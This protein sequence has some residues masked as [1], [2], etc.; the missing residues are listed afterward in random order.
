MDWWCDGQEYTKIEL[1]KFYWFHIIS[2]KWDSLN[3][4]NNRKCN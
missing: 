1:S 4:I 2:K 3:N